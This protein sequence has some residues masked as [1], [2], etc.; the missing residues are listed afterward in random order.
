M[1]RQV[2]TRGLLPGP[3]SLFPVAILSTRGSQQ[4]DQEDEKDTDD[5]SAQTNGGRWW[6]ARLRTPEV[7]RD[8]RAGFDSPDRGSAFFRIH[9]SLQM[10]LSTVELSTCIK[11]AN[12]APLHYV[13]QRL[14]SFLG[15]QA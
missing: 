3:L 8:K 11:L 5:L 12:L 7:W 9:V 6:T 15:L 13:T 10:S 2:W 14:S 1:Q 4:K